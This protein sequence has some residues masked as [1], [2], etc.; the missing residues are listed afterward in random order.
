MWTDQDG[1]QWVDEARHCWSPQGRLLTWCSSLGPE[2]IVRR[3]MYRLGH[4]PLCE[5]EG[6]ELRKRWSGPED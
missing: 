4:K 6:E 2:G 1:R 5:D 3:H